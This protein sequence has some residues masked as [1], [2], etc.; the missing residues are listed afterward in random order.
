MIFQFNVQNITFFEEDQA[1]FEKRIRPLKKS[2][3]TLA[4]DKDSIDVKI[5]IDKSKAKSGDRFIAKAHITS[6]HGGDFYSEVSAE[7]IKKCADGLK[8][9]LKIQ[10]QKFH[11]KHTQV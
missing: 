11:E 6:P 8:E 1:Y 4:G 3:G 7:N 5:H 10:F 2:L 9:K